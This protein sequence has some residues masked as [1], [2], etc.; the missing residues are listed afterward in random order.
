MERNDEQR[1]K[2]EGIK[3]NRILN[4]NE[5][6]EWEVENSTRMGITFMLRKEKRSE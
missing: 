2:R 5:N 6:E 4:L 3:Q 1:M